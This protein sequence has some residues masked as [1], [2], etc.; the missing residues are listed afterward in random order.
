MNIAIGGSIKETTGG[1]YSSIAGKT[2]LTN[3]GESIT[4]RAGTFN[5]QLCWNNLP[6]VARQQIF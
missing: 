5:A 4:N 3:I 2:Y 1:D 6:M